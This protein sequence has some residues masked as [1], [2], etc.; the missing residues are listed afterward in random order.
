MKVLVVGGTGFLGSEIAKRLHEDGRIVRSLNRKHSSSLEINQ[1]LGSMSQPD[2]YREM[3]SKWEPEIVIQSAWVTDQKTYRDSPSNRMYAQ[4][5]L[6][7]AEHCFRANTKHFIALGSSAEYGHPQ[8]PCDAVSTKLDPRDSYSEYKLWTS[9]RLRELANNYS[10]KF[11]WVRIFQPYGPDQDSARLIPSAARALAANREISIS[12]PDT[13][14]DWI[15][16]RDV[17]SA[18]AYTIDND[19]PETI[20]IGTS[21]GTSVI[22]IL[23]KVA[24][25]I[26]ADPNLIMYN[27]S[28]GRPQGAYKLVVSNNSP[29]L[30]SGWTPQ[31]NLSTGLSWAMSL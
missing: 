17:A 8:E 20:D 26:A 18:M 9:E 25:L 22:E 3:I 13:V 14:L 31:D 12:N 27:S 7:L 24:A 5:T 21:I 11:T 1:F 19:L 15:S 10:R 6:E 30:K 23:K 29:L 2:S 4:N 16:A 28:D